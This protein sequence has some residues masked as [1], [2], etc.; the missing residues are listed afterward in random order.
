MS[1]NL[2]EFPQDFQTGT[3]RQIQ[4]ESPEL[5]FETLNNSRD[6]FPSF[7]DRSPFETQGSTFINPSLGKSSSEPLN[8]AFSHSFVPSSMPKSYSQM[9]PPLTSGR[10]GTPRINYDSGNNSPRIM[11][12]PLQNPSVY[13]VQIT[14]NIPIVK[15]TPEKPLVLTPRD[16][17]PTQVNLMTHNPTQNGYFMNSNTVPKISILRNSNVGTPPRSNII[18]NSP[19]IQAVRRTPTRPNIVRTQP[20]QMVQISTPLRAVQPGF[21]GNPVIQNSSNFVIQP[22][23]MKQSFGL[24][25]SNRFGTPTMVAHPQVHTRILQQQPIVSNYQSPARVPRLSYPNAIS[26]EKPLPP[27]NGLT[28]AIGIFTSNIGSRN[29]YNQVQ[30]KENYG[31]YLSKNRRKVRRTQGTMR[32]NNSPRRTPSRMRMKN[33]GVWRNTPQRNPQNEIQKKLRDGSVRILNTQKPT[34]PRKTFSRIYKSK[35]KQRSFKK[36]PKSRQDLRKPDPY[37][38]P[39]TYKKPQYMEVVKPRPLRERRFMPKVEEITDVDIINIPKFF[40]NYETVGEGLD[41]E[42]TLANKLSMDDFG[43]TLYA[44]GL[45][46]TT[47][48]AV[49]GANFE[50]LDQR[51]DRSSITV[52]CVRDGQVILQEP[53]SNKIYLTDKDLNEIKAIDGMYEEGK[54]IEDLHDYR[55]SMDYGY[56]LWRSGQDNLSIMDATTFECVEVINQFWTFDKISSMPVAAVSNLLAEKIVATSQAGPDNYVLHYWEDTPENKIAY[57]KPVDEVI[58]SMFKLTCMEV[59]YDERRVYIAGLAMINN[60]AGTPLVVACQFNPDMSEIA[61]K[62][63]NDLDYDTPYRMVRMT[64]TEVLLIG[65]VRHVAIVEYIDSQLIQIASIPNLHDNEISDLLIRG[66]FLYSTAFNEPLIKVT[67][68]DLGDDPRIVGPVP[69]GSRYKNIIHEKFT[70]PGLDDLHKVE[71]SV[72]G[73]RLFCGGRGLHI[74]ETTDDKLNPIELDT[75]KGKKISFYFLCFRKIFRNFFRLFTILLEVN[76]FGIKA[77]NSGSML[78]QEPSTNNLVLLSE[79]LELQR[80]VDGRQ[81]CIF[82]KKKKLTKIKKLNFIQETLTSQEKK[83]SLYGSQAQAQ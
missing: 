39:T 37:T 13:P 55:H 15:R 45:N 67:E 7:S 72:D 66:R 44:T 65:C 47:V 60:Q 26:P 75:N 9:N 81:Q 19:I 73:E 54:V 8:N 35:G 56:L 46:G 11:E 68:F 41:I 17:V 69:T 16:D 38:P 3:K 43:E 4:D 64:G 76:F 28:P 71:T 79:T 20:Q 51:R 63:L 32:W 33:S 30:Q 29:V 78:I 31:S 36:I 1:I 49:D 12:I 14:P 61:A 18:H 48:L 25:T 59:S 50:P 77:T 34:P 53:N 74:F 82:R 5:R 24:S 80:V 21:I 40:N 42:D 10:I 27:A 2:N 23:P 83:A 22:S 52:E 62:M 57:A 6:D 58:T 70:F